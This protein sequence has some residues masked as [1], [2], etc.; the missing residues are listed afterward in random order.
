MENF[1]R[2]IILIRHRIS[3]SRSI[4][5]KT[6]KEKTNMDKISYALAIISMLCTKPNIAYA[7]SVMS[8]YQANLGLEHRKVLKS[9][10]KYLRMTKALLLIYGDSSLRI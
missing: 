8:K 2:G 5:L 3:L 10:L 4:S 1:K 7:L 6:P 9:I